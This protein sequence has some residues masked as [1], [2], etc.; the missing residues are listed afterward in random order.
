MV[1]GG[2]GSNVFL[3]DGCGLQVSLV[4]GGGVVPKVLI[5]YSGGGGQQVAF[6]WCDGGCL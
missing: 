4:W 6:V 3:S 5:V 2:G 1:D